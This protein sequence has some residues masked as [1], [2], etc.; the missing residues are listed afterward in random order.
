[1]SG[2]GTAEFLKGVTSFAMIAIAMIIIV[3]DLIKKKKRQTNTELEC[4]TLNSLQIAL[5]LFSSSF[6]NKC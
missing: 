1:M 3:I 6:V 5:D 2:N 4:N